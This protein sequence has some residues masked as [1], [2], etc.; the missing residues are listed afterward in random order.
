ML[1][2]ILIPVAAVAA[3]SFTYDQLGRVATARY[4]N[5]LCV[6][7]AYDGSGNRTSQTN[8]TGGAQTLT[9]GSGVWGCSSWSP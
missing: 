8:T 4:D 3:V 5:G 6:A 1:F 2:G 7:Y 9:W